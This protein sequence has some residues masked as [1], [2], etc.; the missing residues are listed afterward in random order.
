MASR[1]AYGALGALFVVAGA[2]SSTG[3][4]EPPPEANTTTAPLD[5]ASVSSDDAAPVPDAAAI[6]DASPDAATVGEED[7]GPPAIRYVGRFDTRDP[8]G[9]KCAWPGCRIIARFQGTQVSAD[10]TELAE[11]WF[12]PNGKPS[13]WDV[14]VDGVT[15]HKL[16]LSASGKTTYVLAS[17]LPPGKHEVELYKRSETQNGYTQLNGF[18][19]GGGGTLLSPPAR[20]KRRIEIIGDS[21]PAA[22]GVEGLEP[23]SNPSSAAKH[24]NFRKSFGALLGVRFAAEVQGTVYSGKGMTRNIWRPDTA[25]FPSLYGL[26]NPVDFSSTFALGSLVPDVVV[27]M[28]GGNDFSMGLPTDN[29]APTETEFTNAYRTFVVSTLRANYPQAHLFLTLSPSVRN[30]DRNARTIITN[31]ITTIANER[32]AAQD[33]R[34]HAFV[35]TESPPS[36]PGTEL[37]G[38]NGHG[39][40]A[41][42]QRV[43]NEIAVQI[44]L[45]VGWP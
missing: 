27:M 23:C 20:A 22:F 32:A 24:Q 1:V 3:G 33:T 7:A 26:A 6:S 13:E 19:F 28:I 16:V 30:A 39:T 40:P 21:Q 15:T 2:C 41:F 43:A 36:G 12:D 37:A 34:V 35:P 42:H 18:T 31:A 5:D 38:C 9:P 14:I 17:G 10:L 4:G 44:T 29:G 8:Q 25:I 45:R 11:S